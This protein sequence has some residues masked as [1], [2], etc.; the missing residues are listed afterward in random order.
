MNS[1]GLDMNILA[2]ALGW[3]VLIV[4]VALAGRAGFIDHDLA[5][6][7]TLVLPIL[8]VMTIAQRGTCRV[9][10]ENQA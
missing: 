3:A 8:A 1:M 4:V 5:Q 7:L 10:Q 6:T 2:K 9:A